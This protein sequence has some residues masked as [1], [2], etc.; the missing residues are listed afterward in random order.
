MR[1]GSG[2]QLPGYKNKK[3]RRKEETKNGHNNINE[4]NSMD[5]E[6]QIEIGIISYSDLLPVSY[7][8]LTL[9]TKSDECRS[10]WSP[11]H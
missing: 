2:S 10:R 7:T 11:Y 9:P 1:F 8:H 5:I 4:I 6:R 3:G